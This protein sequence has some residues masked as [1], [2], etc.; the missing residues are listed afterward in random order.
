MGRAKITI[1]GAG[2]VGATRVQ[3]LATAVESLAAAGDAEPAGKHFGELE[4]AF[5][6]AVT[7]LELERPRLANPTP[8]AKP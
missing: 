2:N 7:A 3:T 5:A 4:Q 8:G 1:I 6:E